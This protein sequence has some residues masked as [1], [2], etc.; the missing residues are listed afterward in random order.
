MNKI[1]GTFLALSCLI[2]TSCSTLQERETPVVRFALRDTNIESWEEKGDGIAVHLNREGQRKIAS[3][4][5]N[6]P[7]SEM[8]IYAGRIFLTSS[9]IS[10]PLR[11]ENLYVEINDD[12]REQVLALLPQSKKS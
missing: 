9:V 10:R 4:T 11:G 3:L 7:R 6:N 1:F 5:R 2:I 8:E 12:V